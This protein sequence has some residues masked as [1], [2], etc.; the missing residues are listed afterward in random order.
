MKRLTTVL[1]LMIVALLMTSCKNNSLQGYLVESQEKQGFITVDLPVSFLEL[2]DQDVSDDV[3]ETVKSI[4]KINVVGLPYKNNED[5][6][7]VEKEKLTK[8]LSGDNYKSLMRMNARGMK[9]NI[10]YTGDSDSID[11]VIAFGYS[12]EAGVGIARL[13]GDNMNPAKIMEMMQS[14]KI[15]PSNMSLG[16]LNAVFK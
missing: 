16:S 12:K 8:I 11:E 10:Y 4:K 6:Y 13:L 14:I 5:A 3:K 2:K 15:D 1:S 9:V 7:E